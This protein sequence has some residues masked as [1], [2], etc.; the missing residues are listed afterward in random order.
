MI[1]TAAPQV[2]LRR[3]CVLALAVTLGTGCSSTPGTPAGNGPLN[4]PDYSDAGSGSVCLPA[5][6]G[7]TLTFGG[8]ELHNYG[9][10]KVVVDR[11]RLAE[12]H[13]L[14]L[15]D[16]VIVP[17]T[18]STIGYDTHYPPSKFNV[19]SVGSGW[20]HRR[21]AAGA[22]LAPQATTSKATHNLVVAIHVTGTSRVRMSGVTADYHVGG[23][24]YRWHNVMGLSVETGK[25][26]C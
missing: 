22:T 19:D 7:A 6:P 8:D 9:K 26:T 16:A 24:K 18:T 23:K 3:A 1:T 5:K 25:K 14:H 20:Q 15:T 17:A 4:G 12:P 13:G 10:N 11:V 21:P 2:L